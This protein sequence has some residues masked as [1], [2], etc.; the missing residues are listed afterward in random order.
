MECLPGGSGTFIIMDPYF[1]VLWSTFEKYL[2]ILIRPVTT[3]VNGYILCLQY[4]HIFFSSGSC[5]FS[6]LSR[7][8]VISGSSLLPKTLLVMAKSFFLYI[9]IL[10]TYKL[11]EKLRQTKW[12][13]NLS[14]Y[15]GGG[16]STTALVFCPLL[17]ISV[18]AYFN[19]LP[20]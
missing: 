4:I 11:Y 5:F 13:V 7:I 3:A 8:Q 6:H 10:P 17:I 1:L 12:N 14:T 9:F 18:N 15:G 20:C 19:S 16:F 2:R